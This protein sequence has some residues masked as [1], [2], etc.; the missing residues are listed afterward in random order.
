MW[1]GGDYNPEQWPRETWREDVALM[2]EAHVSAVTVGVFSWALTE[3]REGVFTFDWLDEVLSLL[4]E[5]GIAVD[6]ATPT[7][8]PPAWLLRAHPEILPEDRDLHPVQAGG[9]LGWCPSSPVFRA[10]ALR[11]ASALAARYGDH[12]ALR[13]WHVSNEL[14]GGNARCYCDVSGA[15]FREWL[16]N[17]YGD[18]DA[19]NAA[20]GTAFWG[21]TLTS[22]D[23]VDPPRGPHPTNPGMFLDYERFSSDEL[24]AHYL[25]ERDVIRAASDR[26]VM[27]NLMIGT[28]HHVADYAAWAPHLDVI[29]NDHYTSVT[30]PDRAEQLALAADHCRG[31]AGRAPWLLV[32]HSTGAPSWQERNRAKDPGEILRNSLAHVAR[33]SDGAMFFQWRASTSGTEQFHSAMLPHAGTR[34]RVWRE[35]VELGR[36]LED[37]SDVVGSPVEPA[38]VALVT[39]DQAAWALEQGLKPHRAWHYAREPRAWYSAF[40]RRQVLVDVVPVDTPLEGY[41]LVVLPTLFLVDD[42]TADR[43]AA[44]VRDGGTAVV[45]Y[46]SGIVDE[47]NRVRTGGYP[48]AFRD[49]LGVWTEEFRPLQR[50]QSVGLSD[51]SRVREWTED[52]VL[53]GAQI[54]LELTDGPGAGRAAVTR[55][56]VGA[57]E[58]WY[59]AAALEPVTVQAIVDDLVTQLALP[60]TLDAPP[61]VE[62]VRR[63]MPGGD[64]LFVL[65]HTADEVTLAVAGYDVVSRGDVGPLVLAPGASAVVREPAGDAA[66]TGHDGEVGP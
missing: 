56:R 3:P 6:L 61:G 15:R 43:V 14:G 24:L 35:V 30:D 36:V 37:L 63:R 13:L 52:T 31:L 5:A 20:W 59:V 55:H 8:A 27:T 9:R 17:R 25:A 21:H 53:D 39:D 2:R 1:F 38:R 12:P 26:P 33:G 44:F 7:A 57:G 51:G 62:A 54:V 16:A 10:H 28:G 23:E 4:H 66:P 45:T 40:W 18:V 48:G 41:D 29:A 50:E 58:A 34:T 11:I 64:V 32:E 22:L 46:L 42:A 65:N 60:R 47:D 19:V 49:L